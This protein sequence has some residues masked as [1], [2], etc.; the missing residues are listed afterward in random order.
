MY[1]IPQELNYPLDH[2]KVARER[3]SEGFYRER[4]SVS[5]QTGLF[6]GL[7]I[8]ERIEE[9]LVGNFGGQGLRNL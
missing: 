4:R 5:W 8:G 6:F 3:K 2:R 9:C 1:Q 7:M